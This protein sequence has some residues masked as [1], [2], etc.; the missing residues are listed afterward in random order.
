MGDIINFEDFTRTL[1][2]IENTTS[3][4]EMVAILSRLFQNVETE[5]IDK[6]CYLVLGQVAPGYEDINLGLSEKTVQAAIALAT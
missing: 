5:E 2:K 4:N 6:V 1:E 3:Q